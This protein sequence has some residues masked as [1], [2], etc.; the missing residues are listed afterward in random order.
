MASWLK[1]SSYQPEVSDLPRGDLDRAANDPSSSEGSSLS[2]SCSFESSSEEAEEPT[3]QRVRNAHEDPERKL[4]RRARKEKRKEEE[5]C[6]G[7]VPMKRRHKKEK[8]E[9]RGKKEKKKKSSRHKRRRRSN[10]PFP[11]A[12]AASGGGVGEGFYVCLERNADHA[13]FGCLAPSAVPAYD[14]PPRRQ[15]LGLPKGA[16]CRPSRPAS[17]GA[18]SRPAPPRYFDGSGAARSMRDRRVPRV[19]LGEDP[20]RLARLAKRARRQQEQQP[21]QGGGE[22][23]GGGGEGEAAN[24]ALVPLPVA[25]EGSSGGLMGS[26]DDLEGGRVVRSDFE[27][28]E[29]LA[30][31][32]PAAALL[33]SPPPCSFVCVTSV[34]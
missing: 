33:R 6:D 9:K 31:R 10:S 21:G 17:R 7:G 19:Q 23:V 11:P 27:G 32:R 14:A 29:A 5:R 22:G 1:L 3:R 15:L 20:K 25:L 12:A 13:A 2:D 24:L 30:V 18:G 34:A 26:G 28:A 8:R 4:R 16:L